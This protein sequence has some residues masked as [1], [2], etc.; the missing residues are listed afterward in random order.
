M[1]KVGSLR[2]SQAVIGL[3]GL[4][5]L[6]AAGFFFIGR[7]ASRVTGFDWEL[8]SLFGTAV[9]TVLLATATGLLALMTRAEVQASRQEL[10]L[11]RTAFQASTRPILLDAPLDVFTV[12]REAITVPVPVE[13]GI[14]RRIHDLGQISVE[15]GQFSART[16][17][18]GYAR[19]TVPFNNVGAG[20]ALI[21]DAR[22]IGFDVGWQ[23][24]W[25]RSSMQTGVPPGQLARISFAAEIDPG[26]GQTLEI[27]LQGDD[28]I[29]F[30]VEVGY[31]DLSGDQRTRT[32]LAIQ[33]RH[34]YWR[35]TDVKLYHGESV[36]PFVV[37]HREAEVVT[38]LR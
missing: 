31:S 18:V 36:D 26:D 16:E 30:S 19:I 35:V 37:L 24:P 2:P 7:Y 22:L 20:L 29:S 13:Q 3:I 28:L 11:S 38:P 12:E 4:L 23:I 34:T 9:G 25:R 15:A 1:R 21:H 10:A 6:A 14:P 8:A 5:L 32:L 33:G 27:E 17:A